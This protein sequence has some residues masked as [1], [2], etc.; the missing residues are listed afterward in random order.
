MSTPL[1]RHRSIVRLALAVLGAALLLPVAAKQSDRQ[2]QVF[3]TADHF[4]GM[5]AP[6]SVSHL[7]GH[8]VITQGTLKA[9]GN[10]ADVYFDADS[11]VSR[12]LLK[13]APAHVQQMDDHGNLMT[14][15]AATVDYQ[16]AKDVAIL[17]G[18]AQV[19]QKNRGEARGDKLVYNTRTSAMSGES[20]GDSRVHL[21]F[22]P[23]QPAA[24]G[25]SGK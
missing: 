10:T 5:N 14:G 17:T 7:R 15:S 9:S 3:V 24:S 21:I 6:N 16:V 2:Q 22:Q 13:G 8:V 1:L 11:G 12:V 20:G 23:K 19:K 4:D 25:S 18:N